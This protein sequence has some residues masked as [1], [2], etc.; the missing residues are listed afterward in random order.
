MATL[1]KC[2]LPFDEPSGVEGGHMLFRASRACQDQ[3]CLR[4]LAS[5]QP[6]YPLVGQAVA[7]L[8]IQ[9]VH[10]YIHVDVHELA[11]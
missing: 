10:M 2:T 5:G 11:V 3:S 4:V 1:S 7:E 8:L 6:Y 9:E